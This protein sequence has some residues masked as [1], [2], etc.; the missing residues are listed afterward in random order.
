MVSF[1]KLAIPL[2]AGMLLLGNLAACDERDRWNEPG[3]KSIGRS[4]ERVTRWKGRR[5]SRLMGS[6]HLCGANRAAQ[7]DKP[8]P[9][10]YN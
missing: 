4:S 1:K 9:H 7:M 6:R 3:K 8:A 5:I 10:R 2:V